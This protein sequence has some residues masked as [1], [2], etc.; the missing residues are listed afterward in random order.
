MEK[1][2][3]LP[4]LGLITAILIITADM[5]GTGILT[6]PGFIAA[7]L[8]SSS[9]LLLVWVAGGLIAFC[10]AMSYARLAFEMPHSGGEYYYLHRLFH[11]AAGFLSAWISM[12]AG[13]SAPIAAA[14]IAFGIYL[15]KVNSVFHPLTSSII[16]IFVLAGIHILNSK[17][18]FYAQNFL[19]ILKL[20]LVFFLIGCGFYFVPGAIPPTTGVEKSVFSSDFAVSLIFVSFAYSGWNASTYIA[21]EI[22]NPK[23]NVPLSLFIGTLI[24]AAIYVTL[25]FVF[26]THLGISGMTGKVEVGYLLAQSFFGEYGAQ[27]ISLIISILLISSV[28]S[29]MVAGSRVLGSL[30]SD[31]AAF[32]VLS[33]KTAGG[34]PLYAILVQ[35]AIALTIALTSSFDKI[36][37]YI[38]FSISAFSFL[39]VLGSLKFMMRP[40]NRE[41]SLIYKILYA[42]PPLFYLCF[43]LWSMAFSIHGYPSGV[44]YFLITIG[45][46][47]T[48][49]WFTRNKV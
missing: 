42:I 6:T 37:Y 31:F 21:G 43:T 15:N 23:R 14:S 49:Y 3:T 19:T 8:N 24:V 16:L 12:V 7:D 18:G 26:V 11:P 40:E 41:K 45:A 38:G 29:M 28:S 33:R 47:F 5:I 48:V 17:G 32:K 20:L 22:K 25:N 27:I 44:I 36:L 35:T 1:T 4:S 34:S 30:G 46:G 10:G 39:A 2:N 13:F 9:A